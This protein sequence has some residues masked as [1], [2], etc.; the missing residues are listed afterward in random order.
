MGTKRRQQLLLGENYNPNK[1]IK[2]RDI[3]SSIK[4]DSKIKKR[5]RKITEDNM[6][7][8]TS[9]S[10]TLNEKEKKNQYQGNKGYKRQKGGKADIDI[11]KKP[12]KAQKTG[13]WKYFNLYNES[14]LSCFHNKRQKL[15][16]NEVDDD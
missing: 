5:E 16:D 9:T 1:N 8:S 6:I 2:E 15:I 3:V 13:R 11:F 7:A 14:D 10:Y 4:F 12:L